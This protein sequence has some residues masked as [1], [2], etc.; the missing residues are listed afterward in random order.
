MGLH[1]RRATLHPDPPRPCTLPLPPPAGA[2]VK[3]ADYDGLVLSYSPPS[4][5]FAV[6]ILQ[7]RRRARRGAGQW[8]EVGIERSRADGKGGN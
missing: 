4:G 3:L 8:H 5:I 1:M 2:L 6:R 7:V